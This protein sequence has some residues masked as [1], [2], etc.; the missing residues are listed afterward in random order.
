MQCNV[1]GADRGFRIVLGLALVIIG[2][3]VP[4]A[5]F[6]RIVAFVVAAIALITAAVRYC[7]LNT[8]IGLNSCRVQHK[9]PHP[10][11]G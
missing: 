4:M 11:G 6:W 1:G 7:P 9:P 3:W 10:E 5:P 8:L 2:L